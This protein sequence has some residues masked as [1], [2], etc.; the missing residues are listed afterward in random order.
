MLT[1]DVSQS[2]SYHQSAICSSSLKKLVAEPTPEKANEHV[3][4]YTYVQA[5][6]KIIYIRYELVDGYFF[7]IEKISQSLVLPVTRHGL[8][9]DRKSYISSTLTGI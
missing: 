4:T 6:W 9:V 7:T 8:T 3:C 2:V 1:F 5:Y